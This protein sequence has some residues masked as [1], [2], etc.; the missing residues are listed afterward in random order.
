MRR[1][2]LLGL[3]TVFLFFSKLNAFQPYFPTFKNG[4]ITYIDTLG[5]TSNF[6]SITCLYESTAL[7]DPVSGDSAFFV[8]NYEDYIFQ[9]GVA[10]IKQGRALMPFTYG[11]KYA[12]ISYAN[13]TGSKIYADKLGFF[14]NDVFPVKKTVIG[15]NPTKSHQYEWLYLDKNLNP[16]SYKKYEYTD[17]FSEGFARVRQNRSYGFIS[18][19]ESMIIVPSFEDALNF[20]ENLAAVMLNKKWGYIDKSGIMVIKPEF[21]K[22]YSFQNGIAKVIHN[23]KTGY[24]KKTGDWLIEPIYDYGSSFS[25]EFAIVSKNKI[26][27][28]ID[29]NGVFVSNEYQNGLAFSEGLAAVQ[30]N[31]K[32]GFINTNWEWVIKPI[33]SKAGSFKQSLG[34]VWKDKIP[35]YIN[36]E[37]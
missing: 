26:V 34:I 2:S 17:S 9:N 7:I 11:F 21:E 5:N 8:Y 33:Y 24:L 4:T 23:G 31:G 30:L 14:T 15:F 35:Y 16:I 22:A 20:S 25:E 37:G 28:F 18:T 6:S 19:D 1:F 3:L 29:T 36:K 10:I 12:I 13:D 32:W 27:R